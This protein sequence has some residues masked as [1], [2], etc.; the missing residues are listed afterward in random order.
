MRFCTRCGSPFEAPRKP[1]GRPRSR[2]DSCR[3]NQERIDGAQWRKLRAVVLREEPICAV[4]GCGRPSTEVDHILPL[5]FRPEL[6][7]DRANL[8]G[9]CKPHNASK[10]ARIAARVA[11]AA[12][13]RW[14]L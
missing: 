5:K 14:V 12:K 9:I 8:R 10:G 1:T 13:R 7:L 6:A 3:S 11:V 2:C 4:P